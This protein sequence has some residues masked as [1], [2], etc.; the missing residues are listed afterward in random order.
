[1]EN[2]S[3]TDQASA[4]PTNNPPSEPSLQTSPIILSVAQPQ[5]TPSAFDPPTQTE[6]LDTA[7]NNVTTSVNLNPSIL[8]KRV[9]F[10]V[11]IV[12]IILLVIATVLFYSDKYYKSSKYTSVAIEASSSESSQSVASEV[13]SVKMSQN[14]FGG[15]FQNEYD[16]DAGYA[17]V[18]PKNWSS[19]QMY[20]GGQEQKNHRMLSSSG[21]DQLIMIQ[22]TSEADANRAVDG[23]KNCVDMEVARFITVGGKKSVTVN[24]TSKSNFL[25]SC[26]SPLG[27]NESWAITHVLIPLEPGAKGG[28]TLLVSH[29]FSPSR[30]DSANSIFEEVLSSFNLFS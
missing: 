25:N 17:F 12:V 16:L 9:L 11:S 19:S 1:M 13:Q 20:L 14:F 30:A 3:S 6:P 5:S 10:A 28:D 8:K 15:E 21:G 18:Y 22:V 26:G 29:Y 2:S 24:G 4:Q 27:E 7:P 23:M